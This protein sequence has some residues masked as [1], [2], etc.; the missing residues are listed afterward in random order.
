M[1]SIQGCKRWRVRGPWQTETFS[2]IKILTKCLEIYEVH[3][4][5]NFLPHSSTWKLCL[6][7]LYSMKWRLIWEEMTID[8]RIFFILKICHMVYFLSHVHILIC[9][10]V[11][12]TTTY[13][14]WCIELKVSRFHEALF[15]RKFSFTAIYFHSLHVYHEQNLS[16]YWS[17]VTA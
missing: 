8:M 13:K 1:F 9:S 16:S 3:L 15:V 5:H 12:H 4:S 2:E 6:K 7:S 11:R 14:N 10:S 17:Q